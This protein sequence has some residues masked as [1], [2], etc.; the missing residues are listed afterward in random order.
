MVA[1]CGADDGSERRNV[2]KQI[3]RNEMV[4]PATI[5]PAAFA[6]ADQNAVP[7]RQAELADLN[8]DALMVERDF[9][10][11]GDYVEC[12]LRFSEAAIHA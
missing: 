1:D 2:V 3:E 11:D 8:V 9:P 10:R 4:W 5:V 12:C 7:G 6:S